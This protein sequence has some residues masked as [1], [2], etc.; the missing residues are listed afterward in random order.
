VPTPSKSTKPELE[1]MAFATQEAWERWLRTH[2]RSSA[3]VWLL[4]AKKASGDASVT[5]AEALE[6]ALCHGWIDGQKRSHSD[7]AWLQK[8]TPR[9]RK[10]VWSKINCTK[11]LALAKSGRMQPAGFEEM[12][13]AKEDGR[14]ERAYDSPGTA[15]V[16]RDLQA[17]LNASPRAKSFFASLDS[18]NRYAVLWRVQTAKKAETRAKRV[19]QFIAML[20]RGEKLHP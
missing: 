10:S 15:T 4:L 7:A 6:V 11:A 18:G 16:P 9:G 17:A 19:A 20:E 12:A 3:G 1:T 2:H 5:Y 13:K 8:F 14:W